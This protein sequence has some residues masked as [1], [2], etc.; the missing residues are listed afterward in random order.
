MDKHARLL[1]LARRRQD[2]RW[3]GYKC[4]GDYHGGV[5][6][7][8]F[9]SPYTKAAHNENAAVMVLLQ[10]WSCDDQLAGPLDVDAGNVPRAVEN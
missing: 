4:I 6:E 10:D 3:Q 5:Y 1:E 7:C 2:T 8:D 9:V